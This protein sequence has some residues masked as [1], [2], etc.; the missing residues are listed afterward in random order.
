MKNRRKNKF[1]PIKI[2][3][4][5]DKNLAGL[6]NVPDLYGGVGGSLCEHMLL[7][8]AAGGA[9]RVAKGT[10]I[11]TSW[12]LSAGGGCRNCTGLRLKRT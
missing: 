11:H 10:T 7:L 9:R 6:F 2:V 12:S 1:L 5:R 8:Y 3:F 4:V